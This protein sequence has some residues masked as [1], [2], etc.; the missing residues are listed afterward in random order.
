MPDNEE[1][2]VLLPMEEEGSYNI[3]IVD[4]ESD[5][6]NSLNLV[7]GYAEEFSCNI[8]VA[9]DADTALAHLKD[10][11]YDLVL[12]DYKM[13]GMTGV[14]LLTKVKERYPK[15]IRMLITGYS[16]VEIAK[17]AINM[18]HVH[19]YLEKPWDNDD[20]TLSL[21]E[22]LRRKSKREKEAITE[23]DSVKDALRLVNDLR[24]KILT[25]QK[26][27]F[28][29]DSILELNKFSFGIS[30]MSNVRIE[31]FHVFEN[32]YIINILILPEMFAGME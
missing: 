20:L 10:Q 16:D 21:Y 2:S 13:P 24:D 8:S 9:K 22:A 7:L 12:S 3:L 29:F 32:Q 18:A 6:L 11:E 30:K 1:M 4:D 31:D 5:I 27:V 19:N 23:V 25:E 26:L 28:S 15:T 17:E 14:E